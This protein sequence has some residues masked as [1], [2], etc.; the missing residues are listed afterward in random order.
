MLW[1]LL[2]LELYIVMLILGSATQAGQR[3]DH[4]VVL[5]HSGI[6]KVAHMTLKPDGNYQQYNHGRNW[7]GDQGPGSPYDVSA[8]SLNNRYLGIKPSSSESLRRYRSRLSLRIKLILGYFSPP[9]PNMEPV[10]HTIFESHRSKGLL[11]IPNMFSSGVTASG[12]GHA[13]RST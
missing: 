11:Y 5:G 10:I 2:S 1:K 13:I 7:K 3:G 9:I 4:R 8:I 6:V 12:C